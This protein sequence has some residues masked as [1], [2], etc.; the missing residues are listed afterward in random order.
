LNGKEHALVGQAEMHVTVPFDGPCI[1]FD[2]VYA[3]LVHKL[4]HDIDLIN[5]EFG[6][7]VK[8]AR[9]CKRA[10]GIAGTIVVLS[11]ACG[12]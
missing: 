8:I 12:T 1:L 7:L 11:D 10:L 6:S 4:L 2:G 5:G 3:R 9:M